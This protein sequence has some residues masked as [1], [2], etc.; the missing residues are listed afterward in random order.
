MTWETR[1]AILID[2]ANNDRVFDVNGA[3]VGIKHL[4]AKDGE[5]LTADGSYFGVKAH[6]S[7]LYTTDY[8]A[9][10][11]GTPIAAITQQQTLATAAPEFF[12]AQTDYTDPITSKTKLEA[13]LR[14]SIQKLSNNNNTY[15][16]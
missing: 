5:Q 8:Y 2:T 12:T 16:L 9:G 6:T 13:G 11:P 3:Q 14:A 1:R 15:T 4:F 7:A 10:M